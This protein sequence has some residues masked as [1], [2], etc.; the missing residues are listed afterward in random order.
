[1]RASNATCRQTTNYFVQ[2][3]SVMSL[4]AECLDQPSNVTHF[5]KSKVLPRYIVRQCHCCSSKGSDTPAET[6]LTPHRGMQPVVQ[7][8]HYNGHGSLHGSVSQTTTTIALAAV[9][10]NSA[11]H[12]S[13]RREKIK[14]RLRL[15]GHLMRTQV[16][17]QAAQI[18]YTQHS[19]NIVSPTSHQSCAAVQ[20]TLTFHWVTS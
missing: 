3:T 16:L 14:K 11:L 8:C 5:A 20:V 4:Q 13:R 9:E 17:Y 18:L 6:L 1:M 2:L 7:S 10:A 12:P 15:S 19:R